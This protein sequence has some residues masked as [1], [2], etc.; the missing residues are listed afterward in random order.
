MSAASKPHSTLY[1]YDVKFMDGEDWVGVEDHKALIAR[2]NDLVEQL[3]AA[4]GE[5]DAYRETLMLLANG[6]VDFSQWKAVYES[7]SS[8]AKRFPGCPGPDHYGDHSGEGG[9]GGFGD[10]CGVVSSAKERQ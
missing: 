3:E 10:E 1:R 5:R 7:A 2:Y 8:P 4:Q 9:C 6:T